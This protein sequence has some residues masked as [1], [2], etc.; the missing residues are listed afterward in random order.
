[1][2]MWLRVARGV[3]AAAVCAI[4]FSPEGLEQEVANAV[5]AK[6]RAKKYFILISYK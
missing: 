2:A 5:L 4:G 6:N 1:M 3:D